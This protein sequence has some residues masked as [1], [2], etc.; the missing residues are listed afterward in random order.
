[1]SVLINTHTSSSLGTSYKSRKKLLPLLQIPS[2]TCNPVLHSHCEQDAP[3]TPRAGRREVKSTVHRIYTKQMLLSSSADLCKWYSSDMEGSIRMSHH[4][5]HPHKKTGMSFH[6]LSTLTTHQRCDTNGIIKLT[7]LN[8]PTPAIPI[9]KQNKTWVIGCMGEMAPQRRR[10]NPST[11][12]LS[13]QVQQM[14]SPVVSS[15]GLPH[16]RGMELWD[17]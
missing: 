8:S 1:M 4:H 15:L 17:L 14:E 11:G 6:P 13:S 9:L 5:W 2:Q 7:P 12:F 3:P 10:S 16:L